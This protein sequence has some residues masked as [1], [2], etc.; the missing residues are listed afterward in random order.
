M[1]LGGSW[2]PLTLKMG[3]PSH[4]V[5]LPA[6]FCHKPRRATTA[7]PGSK[8]PQTK[9]RST[10]VCFMVA[11]AAPGEG[12]WAGDTDR[13]QR[14]TRQQL[15]DGD[16]GGWGAVLRCEAGKGHCRGGHPAEGRLWL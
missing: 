6:L 5:R 16:K 4:L 15:R 9:L 1:P 14:T 13:K 2:G 10:H 7:V 12:E 3:G 8:G 11:G